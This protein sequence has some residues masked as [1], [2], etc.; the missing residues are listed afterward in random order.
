M[1]HLY[2]SQI[3]LVQFHEAI[4]PNCH[5]PL[6]AIA[7]KKMHRCDNEEKKWVKK[8]ITSYQVVSHDAIRIVESESLYLRHMVN[9]LKNLFF[10]L[11]QRFFSLCKVVKDNRSKHQEINK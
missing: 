6:N 5:F 1:N 7:L 3:E 2:Q 11:F 4:D 10:F 8:G 9:S